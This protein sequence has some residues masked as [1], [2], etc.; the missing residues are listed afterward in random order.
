MDRAT[1]F[2]ANRKQDK[3]RVVREQPCL[4]KRSSH[5]GLGSANSGSAYGA[6][7]VD[8]H[9]DFGFCGGGGVPFRGL[10]AKRTT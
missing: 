8:K 1:R 10:R 6:Q 4:T 5:E 2:I 7:I 3:I 9:D